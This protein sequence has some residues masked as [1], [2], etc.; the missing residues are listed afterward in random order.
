VLD[1]PFC[2]QLGETGF[3]LHELRIKGISLKLS[4]HMAS[5]FSLTCSLPHPPTRTP[6]PSPSIS[7][8]I[9][10]LVESARDWDKPTGHD[11]RAVASLQPPH[12]TP[13]GISW[14]AERVP[15]SA[16]LSQARAH[17]FHTALVTPRSPLCQVCVEP[18]Y[19]VFMG[20]PDL[21]DLSVVFSAVDATIPACRGQCSCAQ[22]CH[23]GPGLL[24]AIAAVSF[25]LYSLKSW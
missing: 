10:S 19:A 4:H 24:L 16:S 2:E 15:C 25:C 3:N 7:E 21:R 5:L 13:R 6:S 20:C 18:I 23:D 8:N 22:S 17:T 14:I 9:R 12:S 11:K 1:V